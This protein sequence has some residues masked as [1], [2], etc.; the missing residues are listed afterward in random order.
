[1][2][3][4]SF[5][6]SPNEG[7]WPGIVF[8]VLLHAA[9]L[10]SLWQYEI[11]P[12]PQELAS[13]LFV[14][15]IAPPAPKQEEPKPPPPKPHPVEKPRDLHPHLVAQTP[16]VAPTDYVAPPQPEPA[17]PAPPA[18][19]VAA[20]VQLGSELSLACPQRTPPAYPPFS[21]RM[22][23][24]GVV[25]VRVELDETGHVAAARIKES[26]GYSRLDEAALTAVKTW[27]CH[28][29]TRNGQPVRAIAL[30]PF[31]FILQ[32]N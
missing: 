30:Q 12:T 3:D 6:L 2:P 21:R 1:M 13:T 4:P 27:R 20:P 28:P 23:E 8:V 18:P 16:V 7:R 11:I 32:G 25:V 10:W 26:S 9:A 31:N 14:S 15:F 17:P 24:T 19:A 22:G 29:A 5:D